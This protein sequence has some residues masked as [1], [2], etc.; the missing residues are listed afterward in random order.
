MAYQ[1]PHPVRLPDFSFLIDVDKQEY[2]LGESVNGKVVI[3]TSVPLFVNSLNVRFVCEF[4]ARAAD[5]VFD[6]EAYKFFGYIRYN[7]VDHTVTLLENTDIQPPGLEIDS[8]FII[9]EEAYP[10]INGV[11]FQVRWYIIARLVTTLGEYTTEKVLNVSRS[12]SKDNFIKPKTFEK[13]EKNLRVIIEL[14]REYFLPGETIN[15]KVTIVC[16]KD[17]VKINAVNAYLVYGEEVPQNVIL[18]LDSRFTNPVCSFTKL[19]QR[20]NVHDKVELTEGDKLEAQFS[21]NLP[22]LL[23]FSEENR[24]FSS[25]WVLVLQL[26]LPLR[27]DKRIEVPIKVVKKVTKDEISEH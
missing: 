27:L 4:I 26:D 22:P 6:S 13:I 17:K 10:T 1:G 14:P 3:K 9:P 19:Y 25:K 5:L 24:Y 23:W 15:G 7:F 18:A 11:A 20:V 12:V 8:P 16:T 2:T 21:V